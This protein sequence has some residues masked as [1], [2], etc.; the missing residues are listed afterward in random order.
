MRRSDVVCGRELAY[1]GLY[2]LRELLKEKRSEQTVRDARTLAVALNHEVR[3]NYY[4]SK[5]VGGRSLFLKELTQLARYVQKGAYA[6]AG[7]DREAAIVWTRIAVH[8]YYLCQMD[9]ARGRTPL[10]EQDTYDEVPV[11]FSRSRS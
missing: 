10:P 5:T 4:L 11:P 9:S 7:G 3:Y 8:S 2:R 1:S 6:L